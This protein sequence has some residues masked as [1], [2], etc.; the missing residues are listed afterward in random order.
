MEK[1]KKDET[2]RL[3]L[4]IRIFHLNDLETAVLHLCLAITVDPNL[5][6][7]FAYL[8]D[9]SGRA[10]ATEELAARLFGYGRSQGL[11]ATSPLLV[12]GLIVEHKNAYGEPA[13]LECDPYLKNWLLGRND[14]DT[15]LNYF[16][17]KQP[18]RDPPSNW[19]VDETAGAIARLLDQA[20]PPRIR[21]L[22]AGAE[23][24]GRRT[25][26][27]GVAAS[28]GLP[29]LSLDSDRIPETEWSNIFMR[30]Q[31]YA[32]LQ[33]S[34]LLWYGAA[35]RERPW[36]RHIPAFQLQFLTS[37]VDE[38]L[39][40]TEGFLDL[41][42]DLP[43]LDSEQRR[44]LWLKL[45]PA[46]AQWPEAALDHLARR[47][48]TTIG[49]IAAVAAYQVDSPEA[50]V[51][52]IGLTERRRLGALAQRLTSDFQW[53]DLVISDWLRDSLEDFTFEARERTAIWEQPAARRL[54]PQGK[55][56]LALFTGP[57]GT[58][59]TMSAQVMANVLQL[60]LYRVDLST[61][62]SKYVGETSKNIE[63]ILS[64][65]QR[66]DAILLFDEADAL[67][68]KRTDIKDA[69]DRF[70]NTDTNYLLQAIEQF[71]GIAILA[72]NRKTNIDAGFTRRLRYVMDFPK[73]DAGQRRQLWRRIAEELTGME[74]AAALDKDLIQLAD[75]MELTGAQIKY[76]L[77]SAVYM[78][79]R[80]ETSLGP[81]HLLRG[82]ERELQKEGLGLNRQAQQILKRTI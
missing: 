68:G 52:A 41:R 60:D 18:F 19:P 55:G 33:R 36:L 48:Q 38:Y 81:S 3:A 8:N 65:A 58:G 62:V 30:A 31:R 47:R 76:A 49:Q 35:V 43:D 67:F 5:G 23:G 4:L 9:H 17:Q 7:V 70:A 64:R 11:G 26:C 69:H 32:Y 24:S 71:P 54:F 78:A 6:R 10:Y 16:A 22:V 61:I 74:R 27:A 79:R 50:A 80:E 72:S 1:L 46:A 21:V 25:F 56:L 42:I 34:A 82:L 2:S 59:K 37:E 63:R 66:M 44:Q 51:E 39:S 57:P 77:L 20:R 28:L 29:L 75:L 53:D 12:W 40:P 45:L 15:P 13:R 14:L 73:P